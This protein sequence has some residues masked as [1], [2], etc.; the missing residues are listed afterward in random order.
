MY[1]SAVIGLADEMYDE[2]VAAFVVRAEGSEV[3]GEEL[4]D[5]CVERLAKFKV[6]ARVEFIDELP[7]TPVGKVQKHLIRADGEERDP[8]RKGVPRG[9]Q[10]GS[11]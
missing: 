3:S 8:E 6:P 7:R 11:R 1:E 2:I 4:V 9:V 10:A 5:W